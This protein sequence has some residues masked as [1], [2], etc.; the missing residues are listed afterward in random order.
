MNSEYISKHFKRSEFAC[1]CGCGLDTIN[2]RLITVL[3]DVREYFNAPVIINS[4]CRCQKHNKAVGGVANSTHVQCIASDIKV[5]GVTPKDVADYLT[6]KYQGQYGIG[7]YP[8]FT[9]VDVR[10]NVARWGKNE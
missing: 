5:K 9:H 8:T 4:G 10:Q 6:A 1:K 2:E 7:R 3:E